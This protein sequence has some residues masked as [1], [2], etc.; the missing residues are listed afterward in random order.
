MVSDAIFVDM[1]HVLSIILCG[2]YKIIRKVQM[3]GTGGL[4]G[5]Q[6][7]FHI[8]AHN[9]MTFADLCVI[10][11]ILLPFIPPHDSDN[12]WWTPRLLCLAVLICVY[13]LCHFL[14]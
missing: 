8:R 11:L 12:V 1:K 4:F 9:Y 2:K 5:F 10:Q 14:R 13:N 6:Y 7:Y 3:V